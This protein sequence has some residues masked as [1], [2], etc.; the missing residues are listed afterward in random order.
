MMKRFIH[1]GK[2]YTGSINSDSPISGDKLKDFPIL[3]D[4]WL[5]VEDGR[6]KDYGLMQNLP[7]FSGKEQDLKGATVF[8]AWC[9]SHTHI[10][11]ASSREKE[12]VMRIEGKSYE[13]IA[14]EGGGILNS[15]KKLAKAGEDALFDDAAHRVEEVMSMGTGALEIK[16]GYGLS[17]EAEIKML[18]VIR[19]IKESYPITI[20]A[21]FVGAHA[22]PVSFKDNRRAYL[23]QIIGE[24]L[25]QIAEEGL[26]DY[27]DVFCDKGFFTPEETDILLEAGYKFGLKPKIHANE[28]DYSG[29]V[30]IGVKHKAISVDHLEFVGEAELAALKSGSTIPTLLPSTAFFLNLPYA[31]ARKIIDAGLPLCL[32]TDYNPGSTPS[33]NMP[34]VLSLACIK[35]R[36][37]PAEA[38]NAATI[39]GAFAMEINKNEGSL[40]KGKKANFCTAENGTTPALLT[41]S[42]GS[43][44]INGLWIQGEKI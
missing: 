4:A 21:T 17:P 10:V 44:L 43:R 14:R 41:Y 1:I 13:E 18:R 32:A 36:M 3:T 6:V 39:N 7:E 5:L 24:M 27:M 26:A 23:E 34:F 11:Y 2:L 31:P 8:P 40:E 15:A 30:Q 35:M 20:K 22:V 25:P 42:F 38:M 28:L 9:D 19:R 37:L 12:F 16:S 29:G 33:G